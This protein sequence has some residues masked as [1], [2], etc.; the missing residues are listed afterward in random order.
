MVKVFNLNN[1]MHVT[2]QR[3]GDRYRDKYQHLVMGI[4]Q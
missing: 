3:K 4:I 1:V 2:V